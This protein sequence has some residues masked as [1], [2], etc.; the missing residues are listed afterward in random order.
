MGAVPATAVDTII[1][2]DPLHGNDT[3]SCLTSNSANS[4]CQTLN[5]VFN[6][7]HRTSSVT[8]M[9]AEG[10]H[11]LSLPAITLRS[12]DSIMLVGS[13][14]SFTDTRVQ[15]TAE[16]TGLAFENVTNIH[17]SGL[18]FSNCSA[19][20]NSTSKNFNTENSTY[21]Y[22][23]FQVALHFYACQNVSMS[24][25]KVDGSPNATGVVMYDTDGTNTITNCVF[26]DNSVDAV[27]TPFPG[28]GG[29][30]VEFTYCIPGDIYCQYHQKEVVSYT[31]RNTESTYTF[32]NCSFTRNKANHSISKHSTFI[33]PFRAD[34]VA[35]GRGGGLSIFMKGNASKNTVDISYCNFTKNLALWGGGLFVEFHDNTFNNTV[36]VTH[37]I[38]EKN[39]C[40]FDLNSGTG[41]GGMRIG[42]IVFGGEPDTGNR[43]GASGNHVELNNCKFQHNAALNG[44]GLSIVP[45]S[46]NSGASQIATIDIIETTFQQ[47]YAKLGAALNIDRFVMVL[48]G[49][50]LTV[51]VENCIFDSNSVDYPQYLHDRYGYNYNAYQLGVGAV[52]VNQVPVSFCKGTIFTDNVGSA[53]AAIGTGLDFT[54]SFVVFFQNKGEKGGAIA[55]LGVA[56]IKIND[57]TT[58]FF[59]K[60][61]ASIDGGAIY[62]RLIERGTLASYDNCFIRHLDSFLSPDQWKS[63]FHFSSN[64]D[65]GGTRPSAIHTTSILPCTWPGGSESKASAFCWDS[66]HWFYSP[67]DCSE[68]INSDVGKIIF[69]NPEEMNSNHVEAFPGRSFKLPLII[70]DDLTNEVNN[71]TVFSV[72]VNDYLPNK[73][74][75]YIWGES[76]V[77]AIETNESNITLS[78]D[79]IGDAVWHVNLQVELLPCPPGFIIES[80]GT[81]CTCVTGNYLGALSC[82]SSEA[83]LKRDN[84]MG[85][86]P[87]NEQYLVAFCPPSFCSSSL[88]TPL[89]ETSAE[90]DQQI[91]GTFNRT[92]ILCGECLTHF[93]VAVNSLTYNCINCTNENFGTNA[94]K[95]IAAVYIPLALL[96]TAIILFN[97]R[98]TSAPANAFVLYSQVIA[99]TF[100][101]SADGQIPITRITH[102]NQTTFNLLQAYR[103]PYGI[104][105][106]QF[107]ERLLP[108]FCLGYLNTLDALMLDYAV[109]LFP[110]VMIVVVL[111]CFKLKEYLSSLCCRSRTWNSR[112]YHG[113]SSH[114][115]AR[116]NTNEAILPAF[117][118]FL[119]LSYTKFSTTSSYI[120]GTQALIDENGNPVGPVRVYF[121]GHLE[122]NRGPYLKYL[123]P[124][125]FVFATFVAIPP[126]LLLVFPLKA[127]EWCISK[128]DC[129][130]RYYPAIK[131][132]ILLD[133]FQGCYKNKMR[134]FSGLYFVFR[135]VINVSYIETD[136]WF[137]Q[138]VVQQ[139]AC[140][141]MVALL[142]ICQ[143]YND[144]NKIFNTVDILMFTNLGILN[145][146]SFYLYSFSQSNSRQVSLSSLA[147][148]LQYILVYLPLLYMLTYIVWYFIR[149]YKHQIKRVLREITSAISRKEDNRPLG[150]IAADD[151]SVTDHHGVTGDIPGPSG[152]INQSE[153]EALLQ[154]AEEENRYRPLR[155]EAGTEQVHV[156]SEDSG[157][158]SSVN[159]NSIHSYGSIANTSRSNSG[160]RGDSQSTSNPE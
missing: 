159:T 150:D 13:G 58:M 85:L 20:R 88:S 39:E 115:R 145:A 93:G 121:A 109:A 151:T 120:T 22:S 105:N 157:V 107:I 18:T 8:Y 70:M 81:T 61:T 104:F 116:W 83:Y 98:L 84:W 56:F 69:N 149:P 124:A 135:L 38:L 68:Q 4:S 133:T 40:Y 25:V 44:G 14:N 5:W 78:L 29:F 64:Y 6:V 144:E 75:S 16:N 12:L 101:L 94:V 106:L 24:K 134:F 131:V 52:Y 119:L 35:F 37:S 53:V 142:A 113:T 160:T 74:T 82:V 112:S 59:T 100:D 54:D 87:D 111:I 89:P 132:Q 34:H 11:Y 126:L 7:S 23:T 154:R 96:I 97:I 77:V 146:I 33:V 155:G 123:L 28:G 130:W 125:S 103:V 2:V 41:G 27:D 147:F 30:Y 63:K 42:H 148:A 136:T 91:C 127:F 137:D 47:N 122:Y 3:P 92:N 141:M 15:C 9:L 117:A 108:P 153:E 66:K 158:R 90:L 67:T 128:V 49:T 43:S 32:D 139:I 55:L 31:D 46:Q 10:T 138:Y 45:T 71:Q 26:S 140:V 36:R 86:L 129:L 118:A 1:Y 99:S 57:N 110:L 72:A 95:Y 79:T 102:S 50:V 48:D 19:L 65:Q 156:E 21:S 73:T 76:A 152:S 62:N 17:F 143:P 114:R 60:N 80:N 51:N